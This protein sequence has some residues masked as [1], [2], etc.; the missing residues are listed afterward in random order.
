MQL[1]PEP[2]SPTSRPID[3]VFSIPEL[4]DHIARYLRPLSLQQLRLVSKRLYSA[5]QPQ[6]SISFPDASLTLPTFA[7]TGIAD[8]NPRL[9]G[10]PTYRIRSIFLTIDDKPA[11]GPIVQILAH[12]PQ[13]SSLHIDFHGYNL[14]IFETAFTHTR[15]L[16]SLTVVFYSRVII[17]NFLKSLVAADLRKLQNLVID[18]RETGSPSHAD[19]QLFR[20]ILEMT[21][22]SLAT[23]KLAGMLLCPKT[24]GVFREPVE[25]E[26]DGWTIGSVSL[27]F[28]RLQSLTLKNGELSLARIKVLHQ[29]FP[30]LHTLELDGCS[31][32]WL[33]ALME[34]PLPEAVQEQLDQQLQHHALFSELRS[35][36]VWLVFQ[37]GRKRLLDMVLGRRHLHTL[38]TD[39]LPMFKGV[40]NQLAEHCSAAGHRFTHLTVQTYITGGHTVEELEKFYNAECFRYLQYVFMQ[41]WDHTINMFPFAGTLTSLHLG[42][43]ADVI[44]SQHATTLNEILKRLPLLEVLI[45]E[46]LLQGYAVFDGLGRDDTTSLSELKLSEASE[47]PE[48][49]LQKPIPPPEW[50]QERPFL[51]DLQ[52]YACPPARPPT[53][54]PVVSL[55]DPLDLDELYSSVVQRFRFLE[56]L[57][58]KTT[59][60]HKPREHKVE[61]WK[62]T[63]PAWLDVDFSTMR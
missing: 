17:D 50:I 13:L 11:A 56:K 53:T 31:G 29:L 14:R 58:V 30:Q 46:R 54:G 26:E 60:R 52:I 59:L 22:G 4:T 32:D 9:F 5:Y 23:L 39:I 7:S 28:P 48:E 18:C 15:D 34:D 10:V 63:L 33:P 16:I 47:Q 37:S 24:H 35:L 36:K 20:S 3:I 25:G 45:I 8:T 12:H 21:E 40:I 57:K 41:T 62:A 43:K 1:S 55:N 38:G 19:W 42:G 49:D 2:I 61:P 27:S 51:H 44:T 6:L